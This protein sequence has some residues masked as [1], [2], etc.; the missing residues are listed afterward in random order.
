VRVS[1]TM[2]RVTLLG[3]TLEAIYRSRWSFRTVQAAG[4][5]RGERNRLWVARP[6]RV[7]AECDRENGTSVIVRASAR[8][9]MWH[10]DHG[11]MRGDDEET[12]LGDEGAITHLLDPTPL[13]GVARL[14]AADE[15]EVLGRRAAAVRAVPRSDEDVYEPGWHV[16]RAGLELGIDLERGI[17]LRAGDVSLSDVS[18]DGHLDAGVFVLEFPSGEVPREATLVPPR[19]IEL[20]EASSIVAFTIL[21]PGPELPEG[22]RLVR[23]TIPGEDPPDGIHL[24]YV[25]DPGGLHSIEVSQGPRVA[26]EL[27]AWTD[28]RTVTRDGV[29]L[30]VREDE[31]GTWHRAMALLEREGT[32]A[33]V[34][35][36][37]PLDIVIA[38]ARS[39]EPAP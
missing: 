31:S 12:G 27:T 26:E 23:C 3:E 6:D 1:R 9:S 22:W 4:V 13:L 34:S 11:G 10:P 25:V 8:W 7:R 21:V 14:E 39:L 28:W 16:P 17:A 5:A 29:E 15:I 19:V 35:S 24:V 20:S 32:A 38:I 2:A 30:H 37:L 36:D 33:V 18:F